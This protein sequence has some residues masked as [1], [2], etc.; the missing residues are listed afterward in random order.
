MDYLG[1][2][3]KICNPIIQINSN[4][5]IPGNIWPPE[6]MGWKPLF[7]LKLVGV[8]ALEK[9]VNQSIDWDMKINNQPDVKGWRYNKIHL[10][11][12]CNAFIQRF[13]HVLP[14]SSL[15]PSPFGPPSHFFAWQQAPGQAEGAGKAPQERENTIGHTWI[16]WLIWIIWLTWIIIYNNR[17]NME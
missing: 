5:W 3:G 7:P 16:I 14:S 12:M 6:T 9:N 2:L 8:S 10:G 17:V 1:E 11:K 15:H 4:H 13:Y